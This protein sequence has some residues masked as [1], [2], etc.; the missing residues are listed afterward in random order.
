MGIYGTSDFDHSLTLIHAV[1][2]N[3][4]LFITDPVFVL[5]ISPRLELGCYLKCRNNYTVEDGLLK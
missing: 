3:V 4:C 5:F 1:C 2:F